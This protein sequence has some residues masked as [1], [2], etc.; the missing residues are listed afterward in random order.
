MKR[1]A[2]TAAKTAMVIKR[3]GKT[4]GE[5][6]GVAPIPKPTFKVRPTGGLK[7]S[8]AKASVTWKF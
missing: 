4:T 7:P 5:S 6:K 8:G 1:N 2:D 3:L